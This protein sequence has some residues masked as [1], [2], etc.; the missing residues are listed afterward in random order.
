MCN[1]APHEKP[2]ASGNIA[3]GLKAGGEKGIKKG[4]RSVSDRDYS[5]SLEFV[6]TEFQY[7]LN[8][9]YP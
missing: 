3:P 7:N 9:I 5:C 2:K 8:A 6:T 1:T 4:P